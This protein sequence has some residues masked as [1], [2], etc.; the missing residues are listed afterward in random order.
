MKDGPTDEQ[1]EEEY[2]SLWA[3]NPTMFQNYQD[4]LK[5]GL[6]P[7]KKSSLPY[8][9]WYKKELIKQL[10]WARFMANERAE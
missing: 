6:K 4:F 3:S 2:R 8:K 10:A 1:M 9:R 7:N 5:S